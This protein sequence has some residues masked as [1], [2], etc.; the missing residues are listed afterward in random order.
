VRLFFHSLRAEQLQFWRSRESAFFVFAFPMLLYVLLGSVYTGR[1]SGYPAD[2]VLLAGLLG[3]GAAN[4]AFVGLAIGLVA[5]RELGILK[6]IRATPLP[7]FT[8]M[9]ALLG[10]TLV[11]FALQALLLFLIGRALYGSK[12]PGNVFP[13]VL[14]LLISAAAFATIGIAAASLIRS[15]EGS[16]AVLNF[17][18]LPMAFLS[19]SFGPTRHY[20]AVLR[21]VADVLPLKYALRLVDVAYLGERAIWSQARAIGILALWAVAATAIAVKYFTWEPRR[22]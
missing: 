17:I 21:A 19:G 18:L 8:Y 6:R 5:D 11:V 20:P 12:L 1:I 15:L 14:A 2:E 9:A 22:Q 4:T 3:Y 16:S 10:S 13:L 7:S